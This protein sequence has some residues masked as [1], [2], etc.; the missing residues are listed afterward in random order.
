M[1]QKFMQIGQIGD[2]SCI[3]MN[4]SIYIYIYI[5]T[6]I[7]IL[8]IWIW[9]K[10]T[11]SNK[12][13]RDKAFEIASDPRY[14]RSGRG[15]ASKSFLIKHL[16]ALVLNLYQINSLHTSFIK[17]LLGSLKDAKSILCLKTIFG[18]LILLICS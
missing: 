17:Q 13:L 8:T 3:Y 10:K 18:M 2:T 16:A 7:Y 1:I 6:Y 4:E 5:C 15:L 9:T 12:V 14:G 11:E